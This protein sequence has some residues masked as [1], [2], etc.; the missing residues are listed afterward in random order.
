M[1]DP[2]WRRRHKHS[3]YYAAWCTYL[4]SEDVY[5]M[6]VLMSRVRFHNGFNSVT[7]LSLFRSSVPLSC[8][9]LWSHSDAITAV[10]CSSP[11][12]PNSR[13]SLFFFLT[14]STLCLPLLMNNRKQDWPPP[15]YKAMKDYI[16]VE[17]Y[18]TLAV[19][20]YSWCN[21]EREFGRRNF[22]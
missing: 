14:F 3:S 13:C 1:T 22:V 15:I 16:V 9:F 8:K 11:S 5:F 4:A 21:Y 7:R 17:K 19:F 20:T 18:R 10:A 12:F 2:H 6:L